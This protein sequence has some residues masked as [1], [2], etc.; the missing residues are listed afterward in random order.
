MCSRRVEGAFAAAVCY[1]QRTAGTSVGGLPSQRQ[2]P[3]STTHARCKARKAVAVCYS[4]IKGRMTEL[5]CAAL[6]LILI[7]KFKICA[8][9]NTR[10]MRN[11]RPPS[12]HVVHIRT[13]CVAPAPLSARRTSRSAA[14]TSDGGIAM[15]RRKRRSRIWRAGGVIPCFHSS[16][17]S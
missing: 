7:H 12:I 4:G 16:F 2:A 14:A 11:G 9:R 3:D 8:G 17:C 13:C 10:S 15:G 1:G 6:D 5:K